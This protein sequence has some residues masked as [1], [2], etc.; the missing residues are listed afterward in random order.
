MQS[1]FDKLKN[2]VESLLN[3][4]QLAG[5]FPPMSKDTAD[6]MATVLKDAAIAA[7]EIVGSEA[8]G[9]LLEIA[10]KFVEALLE[11]GE[12]VAEGA[13]EAGEGIELSEFA[14]GVSDGDEIGESGVSEEAT[15]EGHVK[16]EGSGA[17]NE[18]SGHSKPA[19][20][21]YESTN[22]SSTYDPS[23]RGHHTYETITGN[24]TNTP[25][26]G[27]QTVFNTVE[28]EQIQDRG[29][30]VGWKNEGHAVENLQSEGA[31]R[32]NLR[33]GSKQPSTG[34]GSN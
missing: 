17:E 2:E 30:L 28:R 8:V 29:G 5:Q 31:T 3:K 7:A 11:S 9:P 22:T 25:S 20:G 6:M 19:E 10:G 24:T 4:P 1:S 26:G 15:F 12:V 34:Q 18:G 23:G 33:A 32:P 21:D 27:T 14:T 16:G 13:A